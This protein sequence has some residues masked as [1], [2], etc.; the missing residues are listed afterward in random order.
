MS[1]WSA[2]NKGFEGVQFAVEGA[3]AE[4]ERVRLASGRAVTNVSVDWYFFFCPCLGRPRF[5]L[6]GATFLGMVVF[7]T[8]FQRLHPNGV[9]QNRL[10]TAHLGVHENR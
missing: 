8:C 6:T 3:L 2:V 4:L 1:Y 10:E 7:E 5:R 9:A